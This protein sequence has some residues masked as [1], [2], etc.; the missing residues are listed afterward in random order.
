MGFRAA[1][2]KRIAGMVAMGGAVG[3]AFFLGR[4]SVPDFKRRV[5]RG[6]S[7]GRSPIC[8]EGDA[9]S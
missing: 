7:A 2:M 8:A 1:T 4:L 5:T 3:S 6:R 9:A